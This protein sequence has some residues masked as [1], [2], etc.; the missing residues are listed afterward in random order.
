MI[1]NRILPPRYSTW[2]RRGAITGAL[3]GLT[4]GSYID[5]YFT[6][7]PGGLS[8]DRGEAHGLLALIL[9]LPFSLLPWPLLGEY[10]GRAGLVLSIAATWAMLGAGLVAIIA[11]VVARIRGEDVWAPPPSLP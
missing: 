1:S 8:L 3:V 4:V 5:W 2:P 10:G 9:G 6:A 11:L 7:G